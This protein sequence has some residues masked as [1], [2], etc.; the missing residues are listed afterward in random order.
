M[1]TYKSVVTTGDIAVIDIDVVRLNDERFTTIKTECNTEL[2]NHVGAF[3][4][5]YDFSTVVQLHRGNTKQHQAF[6]DHLNTLI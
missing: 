5:Q 3:L 6:M 4:V 1:L 2:G